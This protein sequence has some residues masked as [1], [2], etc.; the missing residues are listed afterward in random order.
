[1]I[2]HQFGQHHLQQQQH[3]QQ[4]QQADGSHLGMNPSL[5][6]RQLWM[7]Q[8]QQQQQMLMRNQQQNAPDMSSNPMQQQMADLLRSQGM[9]RMQNQQQPFGLGM[10]HPG[11]NH[12]QPP[13][14]FLDQSNQGNPQN[15]VS[16]LSFPNTMSSGGVPGQNSSNFNGPGPARNMMLQALQNNQSHNRQLELMGLAQNQ[17][18]Q[19]SPL[20]LSNRL[21]PPPHQGPGGGYNGPP[22]MN[23]GVHQQTDLF[24]NGGPG[25]ND[26]MRR[27]SPSHP[28][29]PQQHQPPQLG[30]PSGRPP[31]GPSPPGP[32]GMGRRTI[33]LSDL[34]ERSQAMT[35]NIQ[36]IEFQMRNLASG[37]STMSEQLFAQRMR[38]L[39]ND[40]ATKRENLAKINQ[41]INQMT[42]TGKTTMTLPLPATQGGTPWMS[43]QPMAGPPNSLQPPFGG[44]GNTPGPASQPP[45]PQAPGQSSPSPAHASTNNLGAARPGPAVNTPPFPNQASPNMGFTPHS[46]GSPPGPGPS[47]LGTNVNPGVGPLGN[48]AMGPQQ[49]GPLTFAGPI[50]ALTK[51]RFNTSYKG[52]CMQRGITHDQRLLSIDNLTIDLHSLHVEVM[53]EGGMNAVQ[54]KDL[55]PVIAARLGCIQFPGE[56]PKSGPA[57]ANQLA[58]VYKEYLVDFDRIYMNSVIEQRRKQHLQMAHQLA[59]TPIFT[60]FTA[61]Q[62]K[63]LVD[64]SAKSVQEM[65]MVNM[66]EELIRAIESNRQQLQVLAREQNLFRTMLTLVKTQPAGNGA[67]TGP[68]GMTMSSQQSSVMSGG[69]PPGGAPFMPGNPGPFPPKPTQQGFQQALHDVHAMKQDYTVRCLPNLPPAEVPAE[70]RLEYNSLLEQVYSRATNMDQKLAYFHLVAKNEQKTKMIISKVINVQQQRNMIGYS[71]PKFIMSLEDLRIANLVILQAI[72]FVANA[73]K[74]QHGGG[75]NPANPPVPMP[76][77]RPPI[78][79]GANQHPSPPQTQPSPLANPLN[80]AVNLQPPPIKKISSKG[81]ASSPKDVST[82]T[83]P[84]N[85]PTPNPPTP[86][87][88]G[89]PQTPKSPKTKPPAKPRQQPK[90]RRPSSVSKPPTTPTTEPAQIPTSTNGVK[91]P[92]EDEEPSPSNA[93][94]SASAAVPGPSPSGVA[95]E[96]SPPKRLKTSSTDWDGP[97][98]EELKKKTEVVDS[99]KT[100]EDASN[101]LETMMKTISGS[102]DGSGNSALPPEFAQT[103]DMIFKGVGTVPDEGAGDMSAILGSDINGRS[104]PPSVKDE[105]VEYF[106]FSSF[107]AAEDDNGSKADTPD[108]VSSSSTNP[109]PESVHDADPALHA[110]LLNDAKLE[111]LSDPLRLGTLKEID[112]GESAYYQSHEWKWDAPMT[113]LDQPW[114]IFNT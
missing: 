1:M 60:K 72:D 50:P 44:N 85:A 80:R 29:L 41:L 112:G 110:T 82:P 19:N 65:R 103:L 77:V 87:N 51:E 100:E 21:A 14:S 59:Q 42:T 16:P 101:F 8:Q 49:G 43:N 78:N 94:G 102:D 74:Q 58:H 4:H 36:N 54:Q 57:A 66:P 13:P 46:Q 5:E 88:V 6:Q 17:Q 56:P 3:Q 40:I 98:N 33:N 81:S 22:G 86:Q 105:F 75:G 2:P 113:T 39:Q 92:R 10:G 18:N 91:R 47:G 107:S 108:L 83:P 9:N 99:I 76:G 45:P 109:S 34:Q 37:H 90:Q 106:D 73:L 111:E 104:T 32:M 71:N 55:W 62:I 24:P 96:P 61:H 84:A 31:I 35:N 30:V 23:P 89:S 25:S 15:R 63:T 68:D 53:K 38:F 67:I 52:F 48:S 95:N 70:S 7:Q 12:N 20:N 27:P 64:F 28:H 69:V 97:I 26:A 114:A 11:L 93:A 79:P